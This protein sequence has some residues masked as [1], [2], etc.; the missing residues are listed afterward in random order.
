MEREAKFLKELNEKNDSK[1]Q[2]PLIYFSERGKTKEYKEAFGYYRLIDGTSGREEKFQ[3]NEKESE[4]FILDFS[5]FLF[6][7]HN[8]DFSNFTILEVVEPI[9]LEDSIEEIKRIKQVLIENLE[10]IFQ[11][12]KNSIKTLKKQEKIKNFVEKPLNLF[13]KRENLFENWKNKR[14]KV[15][16]HAD[17]KSEHIFFIKNEENNFQKRVNGVIDWTDVVITDPIIDF[18]G[19]LCFVGKKI[20]KEI[21]KKYLEKKNETKDFQF[22]VESTIFYARFHSLKNISEKFLG[23]GCCA[24]APFDLLKQQLLNSF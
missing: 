12:S 23:E 9:S 15:I 20:T 19:L 13:K 18:S 14:K 21:I 24:N 17:I 16:C 6:F 22:F 10:K 7:L 3:L 11:D 2:I 5:N 4:L 8:F 1:V